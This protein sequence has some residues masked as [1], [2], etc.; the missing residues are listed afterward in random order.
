MRSKA[1]D[2]PSCQDSGFDAALA[3]FDT[4]FEDQTGRIGIFTGKRNP[5]TLKLTGASD[6][7]FAWPDE[8]DIVRQH[9]ET[10]DANGRE[11]WFCAHLLSGKR[12]RKE[13]ALPLAC[14][15]ADVDHDQLPEGTPQP[16]AIVES[17]PGKWQAFWRL[18]RPT[19]PALGQRMN[20][21]LAAAIDSDPSGADLTQVLRV[22]GSVNYKY[23]D[24]PVV[25][26][27]RL[28]GP[29]Y[30]YDE[31]DRRL[32]Q[33]RS[34][35]AGARERFD[36]AAALQGAPEGQRDEILWK[37]ACK[38]R[39]TD[40]PRDWAEALVLQAAE[41]CT[42]PADLD[43]ARDKVE[44]AYARYE[45]NGIVR[46]A[47]EPEPGGRIYSAGDLMTRTFQEPRWAVPGLLPEGLDA[48]AG[49]PKMGKSWMA[50]DFGL[51]VATGLPVLGGITPVQGDV[52]GLFLE[53]NPRRL[54][55]RIAKILAPRAD[56]VV[57][58]DHETGRITANFD[59]LVTPHRFQLA[60]QWPRLDEGGLELLDEWLTANPKARLLIIDT[61]GRVKPK[62]GRGS[63]YDEDTA[64]LGPLQ[65]MALRH[66]VAILLLTHLRK[67]GADDP[68]DAINASMGFAGAL[69][70]ALILNRVRGRADASLYVTG[71]DI[72]DEREMALTW[73]PDTVRWTASGD[74]AE[75]RMTQERFEILEVLRSTGTVM[76]SRAIGGA[77]NKKDTA[78][79]YLLSQ[80]QKDE[81]PLVVSTT[82]GYS[83]APHSTHT[84]SSTHSPHSPHSTGEGAVSVSTR[85]PGAARGVSAAG[86]VSSVST[87][88]TSAGGTPTGYD[89]SEQSFEPG[90]YPLMTPLMDGP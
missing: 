4:V 68:L 32:P 39:A 34:E 88:S 51:G 40:V 67:M 70:G 3:L 27:L 48:L 37:L 59:G 13:D 83:L 44:R 15:Y 62:A 89:P 52:L 7:S 74:A 1:H 56:T 77:L 35:T 66:R 69:D 61:I 28:D 80:M 21:R 9:I 6:R 23:P 10:S 53:D 65:T 49:K 60:N 12:R 86:A 64:A 85:E 72:Q 54:Q 5:D 79:R 36:T 42:P 2:L 33:S 78:I 58:F 57:Q 11:V 73:N 43:K 82:K 76:S 16:T 45:P 8:R 19:A 17:S 55:D 25:R 30:S 50:L 38:L 41:N 18:D 31:M 63:S 84:P 46:I 87:V 22:P 29:S 47:T 75:A 26:L 24:H 71:R 14:L 20:E 90:G 81:T